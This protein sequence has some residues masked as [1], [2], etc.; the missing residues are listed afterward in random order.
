MNLKDPKTYLKELKGKYD[1]LREITQR[2]QH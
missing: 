2:A 1:K